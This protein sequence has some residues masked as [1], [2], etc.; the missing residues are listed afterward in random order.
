MDKLFGADGKE[1][2]LVLVQGKADAIEALGG[3]RK[4]ASEALRL[5][6]E[7]YGFP[8]ETLLVGGLPIVP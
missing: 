3:T 1:S 7:K 6:K 2:V 8:E 5:L 4:S